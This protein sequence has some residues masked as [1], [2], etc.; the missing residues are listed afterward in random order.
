M[1]MNYLKDVEIHQFEE[2]M[3]LAECGFETMAMAE[4]EWAA[5]QESTDLNDLSLFKA[6]QLCFE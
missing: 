1:D 5:I 3:T 6:E 2:S 4:H